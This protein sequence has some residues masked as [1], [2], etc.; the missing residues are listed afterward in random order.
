MALKLLVLSYDYRPSI[1]GVATCAHYIANSLA[2]INDVQVEV[3][4][5]ISKESAEVISKATITRIPLP[6]SA[7]RSI[8]HYSSE[9]ENKIKVSSPDAIVCLLWMPDGVATYLKNCGIP[10]FLFAHGVEVFESY[11][12]VR[13]I[14]RS[15]LSPLKKRVF[16]K[17]KEVWAVSHY[18]KEKVISF[19]EVE[20]DKVHVVFNGVDSSLLT[21][22]EKNQKII[23]KLNL[24]DKFLFLTITRLE[25]YKGV[26]QVLWALSKLKQANKVSGIHYLIGGTGPDR[27]RLE[28]IVAQ[29]ELAEL[30]TFLGKIPSDELMEYYRV[31]DLFVMMSREDLKTPNVEGFGLVYLEAAACGK[32]SLAGNSGGIPDAVIDG[33]TGWLCD[34]ND[35]NKIAE[36]LFKLSQDKALVERM[37]SQA[38]IHA[39]QNRDW[40]SMG[41]MLEQR[42]RNHVRN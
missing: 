18:T 23:E 7:L 35:S 22:G 17:A 31:C 2:S 13:K 10:Y 1:G 11:S 21:T 15:F 40:K 12:S 9:L 26:D 38:R 39:C 6:T 25:D 24:K 19:C 30:V 20:A 4:A 16:Q 8:W 27:K 37:G 5:P 3:I 41:Q 33:Q 29:L 36:Y 32:A 14:L 28:E 42:I 34:P